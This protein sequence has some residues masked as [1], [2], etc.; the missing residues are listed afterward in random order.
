MARKLN[1][2]VVTKDIAEFL[3]YSVLVLALRAR[4]HTVRVLAEGL[5][6]ERWVKSGEVLYGGNNPPDSDLETDLNPLEILSS[7][8]PD[9]VLVGLG[10][11]IN[12]A[13][14]FGLVA[15]QRG[16]KLG[17]VE[18]VWGVH[19][20]S[21]AVPDFVCTLDSFGRQMVERNDQ[22]KAAR[23]PRVYITG[24]PAWDELNGLVAGNVG[25]EIYDFLHGGLPVI[26]FAGQDESTTPAL[27]GLVDA[28]EQ[29]GTSYILLPRLHPKFASRDDC[30]VP[31]L[32]TL[33]GVK[34]GHVLWVGSDK[35]TTR[36]LIA[37]SQVTVSIYSNALVE[38]ALLGSLPVSWNSA[39][40][41]EKMSAAL[42][43]LAQFPL[44]GLD[45]AVEVKSADEFLSRVPFDFTS[46]AYHEYLDRCR[47]TF[48][49]DGKNTDRVVR[50]IEA[51]FGP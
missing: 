43:G 47:A 36:Q 29:R 2:F 15:N 5:S 7:V 38:A 40:G 49:N 10:A 26:L 20:R 34:K 17:F 51:Q 44:V 16:I 45:C 4:G 24:S 14:K 11:P 46:A 1:I 9:L 39:V 33:A 21:T 6:R 18:D 28:L 19:S 13:E 41:R 31:W 25:D 42:G 23:F 48:P 22:Y 35:A 8:Q 27:A 37:L 50:A 3:I 12:W 32:K 30:V